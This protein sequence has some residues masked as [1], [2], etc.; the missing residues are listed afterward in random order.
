MSSNIQDLD[1]DT[2]SILSEPVVRKKVRFQDPEDHEPEPRSTIM[3]VLKEAGV[4]F[5]TV[6]ALNNKYSLQVLEQIPYTSE[7]TI[8][9]I[10]AFLTAII[11]LL[12]KSTI[13][14]N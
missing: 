4:L 5:V 1:S 10:V 7:L 9:L 6:A 3:D 2:S 12:A 11:F 14:G 8:P 13:L